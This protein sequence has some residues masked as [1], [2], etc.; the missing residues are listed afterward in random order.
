MCIV[1]D[2]GGEF[3]DRLHVKVLL[4]AHQLAEPL[5]ADE[6]RA[7]F[8]A[9]HREELALQSVEPIQDVEV[10]HRCDLGLVT[11]RGVVDHGDQVVDI[12]V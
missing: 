8:V 4:V 9:D 10:G 5:D 1:V 11:R 2:V 7:K 6:R 12:S 3:L